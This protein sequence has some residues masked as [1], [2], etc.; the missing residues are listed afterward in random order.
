MF[1]I[2][3]NQA[4]GQSAW[5]LPDPD[6]GLQRRQHR[7]A[8]FFGLTTFAIAAVAAVGVSIAPSNDFDARGCMAGAQPAQ[9]VEFLIDQSDPFP[10]DVLALAAAEVHRHFK[11]IGIGDIFSLLL[12]GQREGE[13][14][15][16]NSSRR[17]I[18]ETFS[19]CRP[20]RGNE[21]SKWFDN[22]KKRE[23]AYQEQFK[24]PFDLGLDRVIESKKADTSPLIET[25]H[26][27]A[28]R[29]AY[30]GGGQ[31]RTL[32]W[33][34]D[35]LQNTELAS[36]YT[37]SYRFEQFSTNNSAYLS[38]LHKRFA[39]MCVEMFIVSSKYPHQMAW[40]E[41]EAFWRD[42]W[43]AAGVTCLTIKKS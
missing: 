22:R 42:Y 36:F 24:I 37:G 43:A 2:H 21:V 17:Y 40:P 31:G 29:T 19:R 41:I 15:Q 5:Q 13:V 10:I 23:Q 4:S 11:Q 12:L 3:H 33:F 6:A 8:L 18:D 28:G 20:P 14:V 30:D 26:T 1:A 38:G 7:L 25:L 39:G 27:I 35:G 16:S 34:T 32:V 9:A